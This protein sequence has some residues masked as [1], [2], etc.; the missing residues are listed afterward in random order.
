ME[1]QPGGTR[2]RRVGLLL[3]FVLIS[4]GVVVVWANYSTDFDCIHQLMCHGDGGLTA[5]GADRLAASL[6]FGSAQPNR[7]GDGLPSGLGAAAL[8]VGGLIVAGA[9]LSGRL[10]RNSTQLARESA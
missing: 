2:G 10:A 7:T 1:Q 9:W 4:I 3:G 5:T 6:G 8:V